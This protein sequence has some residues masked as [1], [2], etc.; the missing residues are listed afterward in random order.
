MAQVSGI[1]PRPVDAG[2]FVS[3]RPALLHALV[4]QLEAEHDRWFLWLPVLFG[5]GIAFYF[6]LPS[7]PLLIVAIVP[8]IATLGVHL[9]GPRTGIAGLVTGAV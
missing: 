6:L 8:A 5:A 2:G 4:R 3:D 9:A 7:E 1:E